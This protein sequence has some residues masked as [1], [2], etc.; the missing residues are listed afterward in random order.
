VFGAERLELVAMTKEEVEGDLGVG[1][2]SLARLGVKAR[3]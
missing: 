2:M 3:R 1:G